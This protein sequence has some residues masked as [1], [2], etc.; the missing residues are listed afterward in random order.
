MAKLLCPMNCAS[1]ER[2]QPFC[3]PASSSHA[4]SPY[5][6]SVVTELLTPNTPYRRTQACTMPAFGQLQP[7]SWANSQLLLEFIFY[8]S[9]IESFFSLTLNP[10]PYC[11]C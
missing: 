7:S 2:G 4:S 10:I 8:V 9:S 11:H 3:I 5:S 6:H 1:V